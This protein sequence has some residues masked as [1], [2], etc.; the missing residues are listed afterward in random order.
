MRLRSDTTSDLVLVCD[1]ASPALPPEYGTLGLDRTM[2]HRHIAFDIGAADV[3]ASLSEKLNVPAVLSTFSRLLIDP[4]R[5]LDDQTLIVKS[6]DGVFIPGNQSLDAAEIN[7]RVQKFHCR[8]HEAVDD[9]FTAASA[10][11]IIPA[12]VGIHS[13]TPIMNGF[14]R[15]W[16]VAVLW[17]R[18]PRLAQA[19]LRRLQ[20]EN[21]LCVG[22]NEPYSGRLAG[23]SMDWHGG[24]NG[25]PNAVIEIR[26]DLIDTRHGVEHWAGR[27]AR[28]LAEV[29]ADRTLFEKRYF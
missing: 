25:L 29:S 20:A 19:L 24:R 3:T 14:E 4:N 22:D 12:F 28:G 18:D 13:F 21:D 6:S 17:N 26:Q 9:Q 27:L 11:G 2:F 16:E 10:A 7:S 15:P 1:H 23:Y 5:A 8:F